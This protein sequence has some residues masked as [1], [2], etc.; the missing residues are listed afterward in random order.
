MRSAID[1]YV[2]SRGMSVHR[3]D[4]GAVIGDLFADVRQKTRQVVDEQLS[5]VASLSDAEYEK[6]LPVELTAFASVSGAAKNVSGVEVPKTGAQVRARFAAV[7]GVVLLL[8]GIGMLFGWKVF[9]ERKTATSGSLPTAMTP[10]RAAVPANV[11]LRMTAFP[12]NAKLYLA[13]ELLPSNPVT[14]ELPRDTA[15]SITLEAKADG[16]QSERRT[17]RLDRDW[18]IVLALTAI[19]PAAAPSASVAPEVASRPLHRS[20]SKT[21]VVPIKTDCNPPYFVDERGVKTYKKDC[22]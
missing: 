13:G 4:I 20:S 14:E 2:E 9:G 8:F 6:V 11:S 16:Y 19:A 10:P 22:L 18:D 12:A 3:R 5:K 15:R 1:A 17:I 7:G 21:V